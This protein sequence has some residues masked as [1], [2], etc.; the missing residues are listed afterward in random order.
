MLIRLPGTVAG[1]GVTEGLVDFPLSIK[2]HYGIP[3]NR[4]KIV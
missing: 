1:I 3:A 2:G 4:C